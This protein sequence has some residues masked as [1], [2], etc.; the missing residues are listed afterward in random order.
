MEKIGK[1]I[2]FRVYRRS[3]LLCSP[4][5]EVFEGNHWTTEGM[6]PGHGGHHS[7]SG[8]DREGATLTSP[9]PNCLLSM[10]LSFSFAFSSSNSVPIRVRTL[11]RLRVAVTAAGATVAVAAEPPGPRGGDE[12][13]KHRSGTNS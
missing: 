1:Y 11:F 2:G 5:I 7:A 13:K 3:Y 6:R 8:T 9:M 12:P 10:A 4:V